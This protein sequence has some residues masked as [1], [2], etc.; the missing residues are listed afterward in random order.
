MDDVQQ[1][2]SRIDSQGV[3]EAMHDK[4]YVLLSQFLPVKYCNE[5]IAR[6]DDLQLIINLESRLLFGFQPSII[7]DLRHL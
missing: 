5:L 7:T 1:K 6:Y 3:S 4:G 2:I